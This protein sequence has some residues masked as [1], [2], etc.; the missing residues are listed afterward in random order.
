MKVIVAALVVA[1]IG[2]AIGV[3]NGVIVSKMGVN[4][5]IAT[6]GTGTVV[7]G[8]NYAIRAE[9]RCN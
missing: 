5:F 1:A 9:F 2:A 4:A 7:V 8:L 6:L 3:V